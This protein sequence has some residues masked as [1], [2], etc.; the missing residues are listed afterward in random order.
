L[1]KYKNTEPEK[2]KTMYAKGK[3]IWVVDEAGMCGSRKF[4]DLMNV[5]READASRLY[6]GP[7]TISVHRGRE[8][9]Q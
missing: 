6:R 8:N 9:V 4:L 3:E 1:L 2:R 5:A 7:Q